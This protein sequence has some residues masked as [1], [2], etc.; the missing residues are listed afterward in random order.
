VVKEQEP[1]SGLTPVRL[2]PGPTVD[3]FQVKW[4]YFWD[5]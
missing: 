5:L 4:S 1:T 3:T 2:G